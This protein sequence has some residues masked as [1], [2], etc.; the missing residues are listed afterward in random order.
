MGNEDTP[1][2][3]ARLQRRWDADFVSGE[4]GVSRSTYLRWEAGKQIPR[5]G[6]L[7]ALCRIF[8]LSPLALG[9]VRP[10]T[11]QTNPEQGRKT[12]K[13]K[14]REKQPSYTEA[15]ALWADSLEAC[16]LAYMVGGQ[17]EIEQ[18]LPNYFVNLT[19]P[20]LT[21]GPHQRQAASLMAQVYQLSGLLKLQRGDFA[22]ALAEGTQALV[23]S[24][25]AQ[26]WN[27]YVAS[28]IRMA[29]ILMAY[30]RAGAA[31]N[32]YNDA[33]RCV[34]EHPTIISPLLQSWIF[35][36]LGEIQ[37]T[38][39]RER[40]AMRFMQLAMTVF[41]EEPQN[42]PAY[43]YCR[44]DSSLIFLYE[45]LLLLRR[46]YPKF[47]WEAFSQIDELR[48]APPERI[49]A[50]FLKYKV[51]TSCL[52]GNMIQ[53]CI[54]MEAAARAAREIQSDLLFSEIYALYEHMLAL[55]G[56]EPRVRAL[57]ELFLR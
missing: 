32:A 24:Q 48:P 18:K 26:D 34:N 38:M 44:W 28:Q 9:F 20:T 47:A 37:A 50:E 16:W 31:L 42:D 56:T 40:D 33:L 55:W 15:L 46:G 11:K 30:K 21:P 5:P 12:D 43:S 49:R 6:A 51:Y 52:L 41:P 1:L 10:E 4:V 29:T 53:T 2:K 14:S 19:R 27:A 8:G 35:C 39:G 17:E 57:A 36:G 23:Y 7:R 22:G 45:G 54:Y 25:L 13:Q 3:A